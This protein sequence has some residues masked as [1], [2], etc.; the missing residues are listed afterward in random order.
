M[1]FPDLPALMTGFQ[2]IKTNSVLAPLLVLAL[3]LGIIV[4]VATALLGGGSWIVGTLWIVFIA[5]IVFTLAAYVYW[6]RQDPVRL[7]TE[8]YQLEQ[9]KILMI[10][11]E[12]NPN[13]LTIIESQ[14][15]ANS[16]VQQIGFK[17]P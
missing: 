2:R 17:N 12:R 4:L 8:D 5:E 3:I 14:P 1:R 13:D 7:Q 10:G 16:S 9:Q 11:D 6:A 15:T